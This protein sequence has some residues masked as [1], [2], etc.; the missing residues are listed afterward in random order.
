MQKNQLV[1]NTWRIDTDS[2]R[3]LETLKVCVCDGRRDHLSS[4][5]VNWKEMQHYPKKLSE[6]ILKGVRAELTA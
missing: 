4:K 6:L 1:K 2:A 5:D 3:S